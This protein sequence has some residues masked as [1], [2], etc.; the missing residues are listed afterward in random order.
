LKSEKQG[1]LNVKTDANGSCYAIGLPFGHATMPTVR[2][3]ESKSQTKGGYIILK[4]SVVI[5]FDMSLS[6][7]SQPLPEARDVGRQQL[8]VEKRILYRRFPLLSN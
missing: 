8:R 2:G 6:R 1:R 4:D 5:E 7:W 3:S